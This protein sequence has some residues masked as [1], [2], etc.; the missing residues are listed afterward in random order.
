[1]E[2]TKTTEFEFHYRKL[3]NDILKAHESNNN[4]SYLYSI[5]QYFGRLS[6]WNSIYKDK[7]EIYDFIPDYLLSSYGDKILRLYEPLD[8]MSTFEEAK[9]RLVDLKRCINDLG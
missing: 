8:S 7:I 6:A 3:Y 5:V 1:M 2:H 4:Q 9:V